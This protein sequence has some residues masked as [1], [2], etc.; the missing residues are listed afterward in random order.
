[1]KNSNERDR[2]LLA[3]RRAPHVAAGVGRKESVPMGDRSN[4]RVRQD[5]RRVEAGPPGGWRERRRFAERRLI[6]V[7]ETFYWEWAGHMTLWLTNKRSEA[8]AHKGAMSKMGGLAGRDEDRR[9]KA[10]RRQVDF[11]PPL[12]RRERRHRA[13]R[14]MI[15]V[16]EVGLDQWLSSIDLK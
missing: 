5:R 12:K 11:G 9:R 7:T 14:R 15:E 13:E 6:N 1:M 16:R 4:R 10:D 2:L 8:D 3:H